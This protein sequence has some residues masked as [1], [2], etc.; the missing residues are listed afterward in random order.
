[1]QLQVTGSTHNIDLSGFAQVPNLRFTGFVDDIRTVV[2]GSGI[3][4]AP[5]RQGGGTRL[6]IL[7]AMALGTPVVS[8]SKG[9]EGLQVVHGEHALIAD[10][11]REFADAIVRLR[12]DAD[13]RVNIA[14]RARALVEQSYGWA[15]IGQ[16]M[17][18]MLEAM[19]YHDATA[20]V[21]PSLRLSRPVG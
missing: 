12:S 4:I 6:K 13:L 20:S 18:D 3:A 8:T 9:V 14:R 16:G 1:M 10:T 17:S 5:L 11:A 15:N 2:A 19:T 7:E 21:R